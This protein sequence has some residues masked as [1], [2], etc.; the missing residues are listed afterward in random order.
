M[1]SK[2]IFIMGAIFICTFIGAQE[3]KAQETKYYVMYG[4]FKSGVG[5]KAATTNFVSNVA[6]AQCRNLSDN[7]V[8]LQFKDYFKAY[9]KKRFGQDSRVD[10]CAESSFDTYEKAENSA[11]KQLPIITRKNAKTIS[12]PISA[13]YAMTD[14]FIF[15]SLIV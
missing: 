7:G 1:K 10:W 3:L 4:W 14:L 15:N 2:L 11:G 13:F 8:K 9:C 12:F 5:E 6:K